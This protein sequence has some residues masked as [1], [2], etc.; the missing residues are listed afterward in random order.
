MMDY[1]GRLHPKGYLFQ[2]GGMVYKRARDF[3]SRSI[4]KNRE[5][6]HLRQPHSQGLP[7]LALGNRRRRDPGNKVVI[8]VF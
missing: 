7:S 8:Y 4:E 5:N 2:A 3:M 1:V 6:C